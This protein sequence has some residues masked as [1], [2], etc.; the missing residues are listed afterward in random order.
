VGQLQY[1][2]KTTFDI[3]DR[4][5]AHLRVVVM[6]KLRRGESFMRQVPDPGHGYRSIWLHPAVPLMFRFYG[7]R[8]PKLDHAVIEEWLTQA[9]SPDGLSLTTRH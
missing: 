1:E 8:P 7:S 5:L 4:E 6:N 9:S 2:T 3:D